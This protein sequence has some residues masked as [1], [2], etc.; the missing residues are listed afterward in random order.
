MKPESFVK[1]TRSSIIDL[2]LG[3]YKEMFE[4]GSEG[5]AT[6]LYWKEA[7]TFFSKLNQSEKDVFFK[8]IRQVSVDTTSSIFAVLDGVSEFED[9]DQEFILSTKESND[10]LNGS[11]Q[12]LLLELEEISD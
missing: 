1:N 5:Q 3:L 2:N 8:I 10:C 12:D 7:L 4:N 6:D 9:Q 11:L